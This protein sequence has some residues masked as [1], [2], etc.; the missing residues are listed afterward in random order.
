MEMPS[1]TCFNCLQRPG[2]SYLS[3]NRW[4]HP[5]LMNVPT[6]TSTPGLDRY[7]EHDRLSVYRATHKRLMREDGAYRGKWSSYV[8]GIVCLATAPFLGFVIGGV[9]GILFSV[10]SLLGVVAGVVCLAFQQQRF[11]NQRIGDAL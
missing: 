1:I 4:P 8:A 10:V 5:T 3:N 9:P 2:S 11:M 7:P 6:Y